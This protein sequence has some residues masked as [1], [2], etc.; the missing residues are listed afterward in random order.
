[1]PKRINQNE[2]AKVSPFK[3]EETGEA[4]PRMKGNLG[5][6]KKVGIYM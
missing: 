3:I 4:G 1:M 2:T 5:P 6:A